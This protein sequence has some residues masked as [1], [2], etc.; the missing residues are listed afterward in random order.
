[1]D[2]LGLEDIRK[3]GMGGVLAVAQGSF[4]PPRVICLTYQG[5]MEQPPIALVGKGV[6]FD[7]G[8]LSLKST[9]NILNMKG[10]MGGAAA[11]LGT[12]YSAAALQLPVHLKGYIA[13]VENMPSGQAYRP[14][15]ILTMMNGKT[16][17][18]VST[19]AEGRLILADMLTLACRDRPKCLI[20]VATLTGACV[21]ALGN[22]IAG[23]MGTDD[24]L[25]HKLQTS[26][27]ACGED[28]WP[29]PLPDRYFDGI[30]SDIADMKNSG[31]REGGALIGGLFLKQ[32][33]DKTVPWAH[34]DIAGPSWREA[35]PTSP[36]A[37]SSPPCS[38]RGTAWM[39]PPT[40]SC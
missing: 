9:T 30:K 13:S 25:L 35:G 37:P 24:A 27:L 36:A 4:R 12:F 1:V 18:I 21:V 22:D 31:P 6:T 15:D 28:L 34:I 29:M 2:V 23:L 16:V 32:F 33:V 7:S 8:G 39:I 17:E 19:D 14:D 11:V 5:S 40:A 10:D 3:L 38:P 20:D 26:G